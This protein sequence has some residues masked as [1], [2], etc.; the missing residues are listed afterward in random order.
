MEQEI[1]RYLE[2]T[3]KRRILCMVKYMKS[4]A[5]FEKNLINLNPRNPSRT[6]NILKECY[7]NLKVIGMELLNLITRHTLIL[8]MICHAGLTL[9]NSVFHLTQG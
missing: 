6:K 9:N 8:L 1:L 4:Q 5:N 7:H 2:K 3:S